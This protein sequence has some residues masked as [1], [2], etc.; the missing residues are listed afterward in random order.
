MRALKALPVRIAAAAV[1]LFA[2]YLAILCFPQ[3]LFPYSIR[4]EGLTL[5]SDRAFPPAAGQQVLQLAAAKLATSP[6]EANRPT[7][8]I[9]VCNT[10]WRRVLFFN[11]D[12]NAGGIAPYPMTSHVF[13]RDSQIENNRLISPL[14]TPITG[15]RTL[16]YFIAHE[17]TH[18]LTGLAIGPIRYFELPPWVREGYADYVGKG[19]SFDYGAARNAFRSGAPEMDYK[20]SGLY[21]RYNLLVAYLIEHQHW[22]VTKL[23]AA[24]PSQKSVETAVK[25]SVQTEP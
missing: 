7:Y 19:K 11:K 2:C 6:L 20:K 9:F 22:T 18:Q 8:D 25:A 5:H 4:A 3:P 1:T 13:L 12:Y 21:L 23:L 15:D 16:D 17:V 24:P 10:P 14:G